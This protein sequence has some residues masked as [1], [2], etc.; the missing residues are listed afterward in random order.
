[1]KRA[2]TL[3]KKSLFALLLMNVYNTSFAQ[4]INNIQTESVRPA[5]M[6]VVDGNV[7][8]WGNLQAYN[9]TTRLW[10]TLAND[11]KNIYLVI[12]SSNQNTNN[13]ILANG[14]TLTINTAGKKKEKGA[15]AIAFPAI[16]TA[17]G[18]GRGRRKR[19]FGQDDAPPDSAAVLAQQKQTLATAKEISVLGF[20]EITDTLISIYNEY[21]IKAVA[22]FDAKGSFCYELSVPLSLLQIS[23]DGKTEIAYDLRVNGAQLGNFPGEQAKIGGRNG[24]S[25]SITGGGPGGGGNGGGFGGGFGGGSAF[26]K[27]ADANPDDITLPNDFWAKYTMA[28]Q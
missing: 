27:K 6:V 8:E 22:T 26:G 19:N 9:K 23:A 13:K 24:S 11:D 2:V 10:Y 21:S 17:G 7:T 15:F 18:A 28:T 1:M 4:K 5:S 3:L 16:S 14:I 12:K 25:L 20:K